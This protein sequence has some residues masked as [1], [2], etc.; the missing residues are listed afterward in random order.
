MVVVS[1]CLFN[2][3]L[4]KRAF[5]SPVLHPFHTGESVH[6]FFIPQVILYKL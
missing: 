1:F 4:G 6:G 5:F 3:L 2:G